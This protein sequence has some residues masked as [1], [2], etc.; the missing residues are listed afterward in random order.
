MFYNEL[1]A[2]EELENLL[3]SIAQ[4]MN[5]GHVPVSCETLRKIA[6]NPH[7]CELLNDIPELGGFY[8]D[9][10]NSYCC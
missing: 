10:W 9:L 3:N 6:S 2:E 5:N 4:A 8:N 7:Y 1:T